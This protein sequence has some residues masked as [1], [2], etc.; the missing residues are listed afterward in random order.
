[1]NNPQTTPP[2]VE[3]SLDAL[4]GAAHAV[5]SRLEGVLGEIG[6]SPSKLKV[7]TALVEAGESLPLSAVAD[8]CSCV[9]S[10]V[11]QLVDRLE[12]EGLVRRVSSPDDRR[13]VRAEITRAGRERETEG[14]RLLAAVEAEVSQAL[15]GSVRQALLRLARAHE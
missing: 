14:A 2:A 9:R 10:N 4:L 15:P 6:L 3:H 8:R 11:T 7:L 5:E 12:E 13:S 1:V